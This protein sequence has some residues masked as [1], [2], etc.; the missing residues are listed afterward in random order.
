MSKDALQV[1]ALHSEGGINCSQAMLSVYGK[2]FGMPKE[3]AIKVAAAFGGGMGGMGKTCGAVT[4]AFLVLGLTYEIGN[5]QSRSEIYGLVKEFT[6]RFID[7]HGSISCTELLG[8]DMSTEEG[9]KTI[10]E[11]GLT[12]NICPG[13]DQSAAEILEELLAGKL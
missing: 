5:P 3:L 13:L 8:Y 10:K 7:L 4:G 6:K 12:K 11:K 1:V 9:M 2:Y